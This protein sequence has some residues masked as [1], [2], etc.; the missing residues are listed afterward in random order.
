M[1]SELSDALLP[2]A[3]AVVAVV[4][5]FSI[6]VIKLYE[7]PPLA[8]T[9]L[10]AAQAL[11]LFP[12][13]TGETL[14]RWST[15]WVA[16][17]TLLLLAWWSRQRVTRHGAW[18]IALNFVYALAVV[19]LAYH[20]VRPYA[21]DQNWMIASALLSAA[22]LIFGAFARVW[23][24]AFMGQLFLVMSLY[25][26]FSPPGNAPFPWTWWAAA[27]PLAV[28]FATGRAVHAWLRIFPE[29]GAALREGLHVGAFGYQLVALAMLVRWVCALV[30]APDQLATFLFLGTLVL[31][32]NSTR[33]SVFGVRCSFVLTLLGIALVFHTFN[34]NARSLVTFLNGF[35]IFS[36][37]SQP[38]LLRHAPV[39]IVSSIE[40]W[41]LILLSAATGWLF[42]GAWVAERM[43][44]RY[45]TMGWA[46]YALFL[47]FFG[48]L[49]WERRQRWCGLA[50]L[51]AAMA[52]VIFYDI[53]GFSNG[54]K[55]L[56]FVVL[57]L[58]SLGLGFIYA[59]LSER[60]KLWL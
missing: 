23:G 12:A 13:E 48:L 42:V 34:E 49:V 33:G 9:L 29:I 41:G 10:L 8:Q 55:V 19:G 5:T 43:N 11:V 31:A 24:L 4:L 47:F 15:A 14:P 40:S 45:L 37:L 30:P 59:R 25:H 22:F 39:K 17:A 60:L 1:A 7:L 56:T 3:L 35:A 58:I 20:A 32:W 57:T 28:V 6:Y 27:V 52:R 18:L 54:Y 46:L 2:P 21:N 26:F 50:V 51:V 16:G 44:P 53:W 38:T 36:L